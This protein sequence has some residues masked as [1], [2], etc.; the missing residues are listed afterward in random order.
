MF[1]LIDTVHIAGRANDCEGKNQCEL[2]NKSQKT[3]FKLLKWFH[4]N[5]I[6]DKRRFL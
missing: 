4:E 3:S 2:K 1:L 6:K 5:N